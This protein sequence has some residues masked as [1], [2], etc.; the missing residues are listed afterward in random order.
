MDTI[1]VEKYRPRVLPERS[2]PTDGFG[3]SGGGDSV[4]DDLIGSGFVGN[5]E[6]FSKLIGILHNSARPH[7][8]L[9]GPPGV[10]KTS[11]VQCLARALLKE[12]YS[13]GVLELNAG[14]DRGI[15]TVRHRIKDFAK[16]V[17]L[18]PGMQKMIIL[19]EADSMT[20]GAQQA[21]R[22]VMEQHSDSS[23]FALIC[24]QSTKIIDPIQS[25]CALIRFSYIPAQQIYN[26]M[27]FVS[28]AEGLYPSTRAGAEA[29][30]EA[31]VGVGIE[32]EEEAKKA[33]MEIAR[34]AEGDMRKALGTLQAV[35][36]FDALTLE[37]VRSVCD[38]PPTEAVARIFCHVCSNDWYAAHAES[39]S[40]LTKGY[41]PTDLLKAL[42]SIVDRWDAPP[43]QKVAFHSRLV[44]VYLTPD[45]HNLSPLAF[46]ALLANLCNVAA[47][48]PNT[49]AKSLK[50]SA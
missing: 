6:A 18:P 29:E 45:R 14:S 13:D 3:A 5:R 38:L 25:R 46:D 7:L 41:T 28:K 37:H 9:T 4:E 48:F 2:P 26:R 50:L 49:A 20:E 34:N 31:G 35:A 43:P 42:K 10:G 12:H 33:L 15:D 22:R 17:R 8:L 36:A 40:L 30:A 47:T 21:M 23:R 27:L 19:D 24:N 44:T 39:A 11:A 1:W 16:S 32:G